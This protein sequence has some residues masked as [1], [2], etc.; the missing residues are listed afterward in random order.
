MNLVDLPREIIAE[1][2]SLE[3]PILPREDILS[4]RLTCHELAEVLTPI[5]FYR[6]RISPLIKDRDDFFSI[7]KQPHLAC[8]VRI[9]VWEELNGDLSELDPESWQ[10]TMSVPERPFFEEL[11]ANAK[12]LFWLENLDLESLHPDYDR[13]LPSYLQDLREFF[14]DAVITNM[15]NLHTLVSKPMPPRRQLKMPS[16][17]YSLSVETITRF[18]QKYTTSYTFNFGFHFFLVPT[19]KIA[20]KRSL[21]NITNLLYAD[22]YVADASTTAL[23]NLRSEDSM[24]FSKL[25]HLDLCITGKKIGATGLEGFLAC[26]ENAHKLTSLKICQEMARTG[27]YEYDMPNLIG[28]IPTL[29]R[30][31]E[32]HF[33]DTYVEE[34]QL[35]GMDYADIFHGQDPPG[36]AP[37]EF[38]CRHAET[39]KRVYITSSAIEKRALEQ[40]A[41]LN[42]LQLERLVIISGDDLDEDREE[43]IDEETILNYINR[44][45]ECEQQRPQPPYR[46]YERDTE[47]HTHDAIFDNH[48]CIAAAI[49]DTRDNG[50]ERRGYDPS[51]VQVLDS[52]A[53]N[54]RDEHGI[55]HYIGA[56]RTKDD[57]TGLWVD[58]DGVY[59]NP[60]T[61]EKILN[62]ENNSYQPSD[63]SW[64]TQGQRTW[65]WEL[66][67]WRDWE[68]GKLF[69]FAADQQPLGKPKFHEHDFYIGDL[70]M[71]PFYDIEE[72]NHLLRVEGA[73]R[74]DWGRDKEGHVWYWQACGTAGYA[75]EMWYL[76]HKGEHAYSHDPL[77]FWV[78]WYDEPEDKA[79]ALPFG[80]RL[81]CF[82]QRPDEVGSEIPQQ[83]T[84]KSLAQY[85]TSDDPMY[86]VEDWWREIP[87]PE[88]IDMYSKRDWFIVY[89]SFVEASRACI[90]ERPW[91]T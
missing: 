42:S 28:L 13:S 61:D 90:P 87:V 3:C 50:W 74:W 53:L 91:F 47:L 39:L 82:V 77:E 71:G 6:I 64:T 55:A 66:G 33:V 4:A 81:A 51:D 32:V 37:I 9:I 11:T 52:E 59:Y 26:L 12:A 80:W 58:R 16:M 84:C 68:T 15:P 78:D 30:L 89:D 38:I 41:S 45:D 20:A 29:P 56:R 10:N 65:D 60:S 34:D 46:P 75:T 31:T 63:D 44:V 88:D 27:R 69:K 19:L 35:T 7:A 70:D 76:E 43:H 67:L 23:A 24:T 86:H 5:L 36:F 57:D 79:E 17:D 25:H 73:P 22:E 18:I 2:F 40:L 14:Q 83:G 21:P 1:I 62:P 49:Y 85:E 72:E 48:A 8:L 54:R